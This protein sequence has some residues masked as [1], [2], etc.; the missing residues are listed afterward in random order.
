VPQPT[1]SDYS[2]DQKRIVR[3]LNNGY[4]DRTELIELP[5]GSQRVRKRNKAEAGGSPWGVESLRREIAYLRSRPESAAAVLPPVLASWDHNTD[6]GR[7]LGYEMPFYADHTDAGRLA[8]EGA[9]PQSEID[10]FQ[11][12][13]SEAVFGRIHQ[14]VI[15][16]SSLATH[17]LDVIDHAL[18]GLAGD[19]DFG[20]LVNSEVISLNGARALG[21]RAAIDR[22]K[23][24]G[25]VLTAVDAAPTVRLHGD[26]FLENILWRRSSEK[27]HDA[28]LVL[29]DPVSV[30]G[31]SEGP[32]AWDLVK[33]ESYAKGELLALRTERVEVN[34]MGATNS[35]YEW[36][37]RW[38]DVSLTPFR[39]HDWHSR[40]RRAYIAK[41]GEPDTSLCAFIDAYFSLA[42]AMNTSGLQRQARLLK[43]TSDLN[44]VLC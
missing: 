24:D 43:A 30:A 20:R 21:P 33:Y 26:L 42:M 8:R 10:E 32:P 35:C 3:P 28:R 36:R 27:H 1:S 7:D 37:Y 31:I 44:A 22:L 23:T 18:S 13:L 4:W 2:D 5:D 34:G 29:V 6:T 19:S 39:N 16:K 41:Y 14:N 11:D 12:A 15:L 38:E 9:L 40:F 17:M 25:H